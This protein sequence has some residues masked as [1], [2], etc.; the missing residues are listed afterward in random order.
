MTRRKVS[1]REKIIEYNILYCYAYYNAN[2]LC[3]RYNIYASIKLVCVVIPIWRRRMACVVVSTLPGSASGRRETGDGRREAG[4]GGSKGTTAADV[5]R[6][7]ERNKLGFGAGSLFDVT[8]N[9]APKKT[10]KKNVR[11]KHKQ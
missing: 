1:R 6:Q 2:V 8:C 9:V 3:I 4:G 5:L 11:E 10:K 7:W